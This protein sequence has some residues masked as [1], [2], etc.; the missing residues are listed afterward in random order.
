MVSIN[1]TLAYREQEVHVVSSSHSP[2]NANAGTEQNLGSK[3]GSLLNSSST[4]GANWL[5]DRGDLSY[6]NSYPLISNSIISIWLTSSSNCVLIIF[7]V[8]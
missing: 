1:I 5:D 7:F 4:L 3:S 6:G 2:T 8:P